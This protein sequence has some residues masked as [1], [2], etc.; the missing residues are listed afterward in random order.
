[1]MELVWVFIIYVLPLDQSTFSPFSIVPTYSQADCEC[2]QNIAEGLYG[3]SRVT[4]CFQ[5]TVA[6]FWTMD[7]G[8]RSTKHPWHWRRP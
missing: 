1:M 7:E 8:K 3:D 6:S 2:G 5:M 4:P